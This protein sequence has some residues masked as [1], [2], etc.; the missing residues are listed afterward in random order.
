MTIFQD[1]LA[2]E[3]K[4]KHLAET[5]IK[6]YMNSLHNLN[7]KKSFTSLDFLYDTEQVEECLTRFKYSSQKTM[8]TAVCSVLKMKKLDSLHKYYFEKLMDKS[9]DMKMGD[10]EKTETQE[11]NWMTWDEVIKIKNKLHRD[12]H[13][14]GN[15]IKHLAI[16]LFTDIPP[17]RT[18]DYTLMDVVDRYTDKLDNNK[19]YLVLDDDLLIFNRYKTSKNY[20]QQTIKIPPVLRN[21][22]DEYLAEHP[23]RKENLKQY[24]LLTN[25]KGEAFKASNSLTMLL[26]SA[27]GKKVSASMLRHIYLSNKF[28][29]ELKQRQQ[30]A[31]NMG[32]SVSQ[33]ADY[34]KFE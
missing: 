31:K 23:L 9:K 28:G 22:I 5:T 34:I 33:Q 30:I 2:K 7:C 29:D 18:Q 32:H 6:G 24:P 21:S 1:N 12:D 19:N 3:F 4:A 27:F 11:K 16:S 15:R 17:R 26:N 8:L 25:R 10:H 20:G 14:H 13:V